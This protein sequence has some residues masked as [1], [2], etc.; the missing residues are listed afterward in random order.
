MPKTRTK[1]EL[2]IEL[3]QAQR[4]IAE[5]ERGVLNRR[6]NGLFSTIFKF[7]PVAMAIVDMP[8]MTILDVNETYCQL[9]GYKR[10]EV[11]NQ[12]GRAGF[13]IDPSNLKDILQIL[14]KTNHV[15]NYE[16][17]IITKQGDRR[18]G[19]LYIDP[20][21]IHANLCHLVNFIDMTEREQ[22]E[23]NLKESEE[24]LG[25][26]MQGSQLG[27]WDWN[28]ESGVVH[29]NAGWAE[30]LGY[31][32][33]EIE[34]SVKQWT[35][36]HHPDDREKAWES[37]QA[38]LDGKAPAHRAEY[39]MRTKDGQYKWIL[40][41]AMIVKRD[42]QGRPVR[43]CGTHTDITERKA[44]EEKLLLAERRFRAMIENAPDG[45]VLIGEDGNFKYT[46]P[47]V[48]RIFGYS[49]EEALEGKPDEMTHPEDLPLVHAELA[50]LYEDP[51]Y[52]PTL[53]Y[54]FKHKSGEWR[55]IESTFSNVLVLPSV[56]AIIIN[57]RDIHERKLAED[58]LRES[59]LRLEMILKG[60]N[61]GVWDW[62]IQTGQTAFNER[63]AEMVGY[64]LPELEPVN[65]QTWVN[66][67]HPSDL[68]KSEILL[69]KHFDG[70]TEYYECEARLRH[71]NGT[72]VWV[73][74]C[75][76]V[77]ERDAE[78]KPVRMLG[79]H[80]DI[81][82]WKREEIYTLARLRIVNLSY[83]T[84]DMETLM[85][86]ML[87][88]A[89][90][91]TESQIGFF[92]FV[93]DDQ[94]AIHLQIWSTNTLAN[95]CTADGKG[96]HYP[97]Q[98]AGIWAETIRTGEPC[99][100]NDYPSLTSRKSLPEGHAPI[101]R[102][103]TV[104]IKRNN[105][106]V[107]TVGVGNKLMDYDEQDIDL[108]KRLAEIAF[109]IVMRKRAEEALFQNEERFRT[110]ADFT[111]DMEYWL[112]EDKNLLYMSPS[113]LRTT[114]YSREQFF[115]NPSLLETIIHPDDIHIYRIHHSED[116]RE[117]DVCS[118]DFRIITSQGETRWINHTCRLVKQENGQI[119]GR[120][121]SLRDITERQRAIDDLRSSEAKYK[122]LSE[123]LEERVR[124]RT[125]EVQD[126]Y[127]NAPVVYYSI[128][129]QGEL[130]SI[131]QT[132]LGMLGYTHEE[133]VGKPVS[134]IFLQAQEPLLKEN[135]QRLVANGRIVDMEITAQ[136][137]D[138][139]T[140]PVMVNAIAIFDERRNYVSSRSTM[141]DITEL[142][143]VENKL[144]RSVN[145]TNALLNSVPTP[146]FYKDREGKYQGCNMA[147]TEIM[148]VT[149]DMVSGHTVHELWPTEY[150]DEYH[151]KDIEL[152]QHAGQQVFESVI[153]DKYGVT[154]PVI[155][156]K[157]VYF[158]ESSQMA[159]LI[160]AFIDITERKNIEETLRRSNLELERALRVKD[161]F[162]ANM[163]HELRTPLNG[164]LGFSELLLGCDFGELNERQTRYV[165]SIESSGRHLLGL[166]NDLL[167]LAKIEAGK[168][169]ITPELLNISDMC[170]SS[171]IFV[172]Q[173]ALKKN[174][175]VTFEQA[176]EYQIMVADQRRLKQILVNLLNNAVKFTP[177]HGKVTL[178]VT[179]DQLKECINF[180]VED[181]GIGISVE[182][183]QK[184]F[185]PFTQVDSSL[186]RQHEGTGL[187][188]ALVRELVELHRGS[189]NIS[190]AIG[191]GSIFT[192]SIPWS[193]GI[194]FDGVQKKI[195]PVVDSQTSEGVHSK[196]GTILLAED[197]ESNILILEDF[198]DNLGYKVILARNGREA[199]DRC[200]EASP[201]L[202]L[203]DIQMPLMDGLEAIR[204]LRA[205]SRFSA[206]PIVALTALAMTGDRE[207]CLEAGATDYVSKPVGLRELSALIERL[208]K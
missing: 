27:Y 159:G 118:L 62:Y 190:S 48:K 91:L 145:F 169:E 146:V 131:N 161:E 201:D 13:S 97:V 61:V 23:Q 43:M 95:L 59:Q 142:K 98:D 6:D 178:R 26:V 175:Q 171:L 205:D 41:Q 108:L 199:I 111:Y 172:K 87:D 193:Q 84:M 132:G 36:L 130:T 1:A 100:Y 73:S 63:W 50:R 30:M 67:C 122:G 147:F 31:T 54:R 3:E 66:L 200:R 105:R 160:G 107:A 186:N 19:L 128:N 60:A 85:R 72:W 93:D 182:D 47:S 115:D 86:T 141:T 18:F 65:I 17:S 196:M 57:F 55:W 104:P 35:D 5:L 79:T 9:L 206:L 103:V 184:L 102:L 155:F 134:T 40:D 58:A 49:P 177:D 109:D 25:L 106:I 8:T 2:K 136:R 198:L 119:Q 164:I 39:R 46:S 129:G 203:M 126:L 83:E 15:D 12:A 174:I 99:I 144:Q 38:H 112:G 152:M 202:I 101:T 110:V 77:L 208:L 180:S 138:G 96:L 56:K 154:R 22:A 78:G 29:R 80:L 90:A 88:E 165:N 167:D 156:F 92:H 183:M 64:S 191:Q 194:G 51:S 32:L 158:D 204:Y 133:V 21:E 116:F 81:T 148:G 11:V 121:V 197:M 207:R 163:S 68:K 89:E 149:S 166:I 37:I 20:V 113:C 187:G 33:E 192:V 150:A 24:R 82:A 151:E 42:L 173:A 123:E 75:G 44:A 69:Q 125:A 139:T 162:L 179:S 28:M 76:K 185:K 176:T 127:D 181:T 70:E 157:A 120:R 45:V 124:Q 34:Y 4:R 140:F 52:V 10:E 195:D 137:K 114:G 143:R 135:I 117:Q 7:S 94:N 170:Q 153:Q 16:V 189:I 53:Q 14:Q 188:L 74:D 168:L 71:K